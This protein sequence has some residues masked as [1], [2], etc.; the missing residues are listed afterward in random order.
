MKEQYYSP[1]IEIPAKINTLHKLSYY[2]LR[3][4]IELQG[5]RYSN[6]GMFEVIVKN[7]YEYE[8]GVYVSCRKTAFEIQSHYAP[9]LNSKNRQQMIFII[10][11]HLESVIEK[12]KQN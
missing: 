12:A 9:K 5:F 10:S 11:K 8:V 2:L 1:E 4:F 7:S 3:E 6:S